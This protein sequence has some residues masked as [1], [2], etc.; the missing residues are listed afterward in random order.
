M[1]RVKEINRYFIISMLIPSAVMIASFIAF[2]ILMFTDI[3]PSSDAATNKYITGAV[4]GSVVVIAAAVMLFV[5][6]GKKYELAKDLGI[7]K[8]R[9][10]VIDS[11]TAALGMAAVAAA[12]FYTLIRSGSAITGQTSDM[13]SQTLYLPVFTVA[14]VFMPCL[15]PSFLTQRRIKIAVTKQ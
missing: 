1:N 15:L 3:D 4:V 13:S 12:V 6:N 9:A 11:L 10:V 8:K 5:V 7:E 2:F 14:M